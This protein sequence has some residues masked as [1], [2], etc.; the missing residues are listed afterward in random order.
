MKVYLLTHYYSVQG[1]DFETDLGVFSTL[2]NAKDAAH[3]ENCSSWD[4]SRLI[5]V[6]C[7][8]WYCLSLEAGGGYYDIEE[9]ELD[10]LKYDE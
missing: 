3:T 7:D 1:Q 10:E 9:Y 5:N 4:S 6:P 2:Q 8:L